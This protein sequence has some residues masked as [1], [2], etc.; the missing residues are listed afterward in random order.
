MAKKAKKAKTAHKQRRK[1]AKAA[2]TVDGSTVFSQPLLERIVRDYI[3]QHNDAI[4]C[5]G[6]QW[7]GVTSLCVHW[8]ETFLPPAVR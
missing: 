4:E 3:H 2:M 5:V 7:Q 6:Y 1:A 8:R